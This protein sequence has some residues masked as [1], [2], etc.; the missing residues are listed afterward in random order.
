MYRAGPLTSNPRAN[1]ITRRIG[2]PGNDEVG[3]ERRGRV[4]AG[5]GQGEQAWRGSGPVGCFVSTE[6]NTC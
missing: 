4:G 5:S 3:E 1:T 6:Q 2:R